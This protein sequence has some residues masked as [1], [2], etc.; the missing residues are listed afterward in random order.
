MSENSNVLENLPVKGIILAGGSGTR[1]WPLSRMHAPKQFLCLDGDCSMLEATVRRVESLIPRDQ[2][3]IVT[4]RDLSMGEAYH[5]LNGYQM[6]LEPVGRNTAP[7]IAIAAAQLRQNGDDPIMVI[8]P[9]DHIVL[10]SPAF[11][12]ALACAIRSA[13]EGALV[14]MG[15][16]P[17]SP[18]TGYGYIHAPS[19]DNFDGVRSV[20]VSGFVEK[21][22]AETAAEY[23][24]AGSYYWNSGIFVW[25]ASAILREIAQHLPAITDLISAMQ[26]AWSDGSDIQ[27]PIDQTF[28]EMPN[29]SID[30]GVL[31]KS[32]KLTVVPCDFGWSDVGNWDSLYDIAEKDHSG[33]A[34]RG[35]V[36]TYD[37]R[38][39]L[40]HADSRLVTAIGVED[41]CVVDTADA[42]LIARRGEGQ[43][44][45]ELVDELH[46]RHASEQMVHRTVRR[47]WGS[48][49]ILEEQGD[50]KMKRIVINP[51]GC[52]SLQRHQH[53]SEHWIVVS[54]TATVTRGGS[55]TTVA[56]NES[57]YIPI[58]VKH[59]LENDGKIPLQIIEV[60]VGEYLEEDDIERFDDSYGRQLAG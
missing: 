17:T 39:N 31:E 53:R 54:G 57:T 40:F 16:K 2:M 24:A 19:A 43:R 33:N 45:S 32:K 9:A 7:A 8:L 6:L 44:V 49:T 29:I 60:Q 59:R 28:S 55:V 22:D 5:A 1:L 30:Y 25:R 46:K 11:Q 18:A 58:G 3:I 51:G 21:P 10:D 35:N 12:E 47:P 13:G 52:L 37:C 20:A 4:S 34:I 48:Y 41:L 56:K 14:T 50:F 38:N 27:D 26:E 15:I 36:I 42:L 23:L